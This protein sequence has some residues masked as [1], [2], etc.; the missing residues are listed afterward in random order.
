[1][2][3]NNA[4]TPSNV[5]KIGSGTR[6]RTR[7][8]GF[9]RGNDTSRGD[10]PSVEGSSTEKPAVGKRSRI[11]KI[12]PATYAKVLK[13]STSTA[14]E[15]H[16][17]DEGQGE[18]TDDWE[19]WHQ[20]ITEIDELQIGGGRTVVHSNTEERFPLT[21]IGTHGRDIYQGVYFG[22]TVEPRGDMSV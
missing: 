12:R 11:G 14:G 17:I 8:R 2:K 20:C 5:K 15:V 1:M 10:E 4:T 7:E 22:S 6:V 16:S 13:D 3:K 9:V 19:A 18:K 21:D